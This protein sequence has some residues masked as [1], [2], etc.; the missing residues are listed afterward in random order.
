MIENTSGSG[1]R[2]LVAC[3]A[4]RSFSYTLLFHFF[5]FL[6]IQYSR[7]HLYL[8]LLSPLPTPSRQMLC[9][10]HDARAMIPNAQ[11]KATNPTNANTVA[12]VLA[13]VSQ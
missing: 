12:A 3:F 11:S 6:C 4:F 13:F 5:L 10:V 9:D 7:T 8:S 2:L 1:V